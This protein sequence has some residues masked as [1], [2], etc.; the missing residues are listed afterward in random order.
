[1]EHLKPFLL[2]YGYWAVFGGILLEDFGLPLPG[3]ALLIAG[4]VLASHGDMHIVP[5]LLLAWAGAVVGDNIGY[6]IGRFAGRR[7]VLRYGRYVLI[8][9]RR[10]DYGEHFFRKY[11][12]FVIVGARFLELLRQ[13]NGIIAGMARMEWRHFLPYNVLGAALWVAFWGILSYE[14]GARA[15]EFV[16]LFNRFEIFVII[17]LGLSVVVL[18]AYLIH[19]R[20]KPSNHG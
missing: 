14:T 2:H 10:L 15:T 3:E 12:G 16:D 1:M 6:G 20:W 11:G 18:V 9:R 4:S 17:A 13:L 7:L 19:R 8:T 5:L